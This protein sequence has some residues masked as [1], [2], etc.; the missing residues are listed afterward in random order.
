[1]VSPNNQQILIFTNK[2]VAARDLR[3]SKKNIIF[4]ITTYW[5]YIFWLNFDPCGLG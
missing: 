2:T 5:L 3:A 4:R 1:M